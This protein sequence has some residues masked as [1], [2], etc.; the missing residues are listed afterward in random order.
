MP[1]ERGHQDSHCCTMSKISNHPVLEFAIFSTNISVA[2]QA[3]SSSMTVAIFSFNT[4]EL[5]ATHA[6]SSRAVTVGAR[7]PGVIL[8]ATSRLSRA[9]LYW[10]RM[11][12]WAAICCE[13]GDIEGVKGAY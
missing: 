2:P 7:F 11:N 5:T 13:L 1:Y 10:Q 12:F 3:V 6:G 9:T 4:I 8:A